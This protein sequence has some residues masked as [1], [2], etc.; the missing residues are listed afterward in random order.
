MTAGAVA[1]RVARALA[2]AAFAGAVALLAGWP[3]Y[4]HLGSDQ[5]VV[6]VSLRHA[7]ER[8]GECRNLPAEELER[9]PPNM[10]APMDCPRERSPLVLELDVNGRR[11]V[12]ALIPAQGLH[13]DGRAVFYRRFAVPAGPI[14]VNVRMKDDVRKETFAY[15]DTFTATLEPGRALIV[16][17][18][19][20]RGSFVFL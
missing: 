11:V 6:K 15:R 8:L 4:R 12:D 2:F 16:D 7:G 10:R 20:E 13:D 18:D 14:H 17:F 3:P 19:A 9:L 5:A 1:R